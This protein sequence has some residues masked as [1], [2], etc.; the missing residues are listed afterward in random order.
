[1][2]PVPG[3]KAL[4]IARPALQSA[5]RRVVIRP[6]ILKIAVIRLSLGASRTFGGGCRRKLHLWRSPCCATPA[7]YPYCA[8]PGVGS[9]TGCNVGANLPLITLAESDS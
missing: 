5:S 8:F 6:N 2:D 4:C 7:G 9:A 3:A 1:M